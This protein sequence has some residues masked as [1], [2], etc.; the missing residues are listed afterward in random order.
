MKEVLESLSNYSCVSLLLI[1]LQAGD[2]LPIYLLIGLT[3][4]RA[5]PETSGDR[6][7]QSTDLPNAET[8]LRPFPHSGC[9]A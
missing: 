6:L 3:M 2:F 1:G 7:V 4:Y 9:L 5:R 8:C